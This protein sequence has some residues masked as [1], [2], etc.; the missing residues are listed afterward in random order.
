[1][2]DTARTFVVVRGVKV[3]AYYALAGGGLAHDGA[4]GS[5]RRNAPDPI[6]VTI[7]ARLAVDRAEQGR[8]LARSLLADAMKRSAH[9]AMTVASRALIVHA[10]DADAERFYAKHQ[11]K[12]LKPASPD[13][14][15]YFITMKEIR[16][17]L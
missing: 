12:K 17:A 13:D 11:F 2:N 6:P 5:L 16:E 7:L 9:A 10:L 4:P 15:A 8:G 1:M 14:L 3:V